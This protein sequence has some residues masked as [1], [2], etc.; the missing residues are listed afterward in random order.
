MKV[1]VVGSGGREHAL[2]R[3]IKKS[4]NVSSVYSWPGNAGH[5][6]DAQRVPVAAGDYQKLIAWAKEAQVELVVIGPEAELVAGLADQLRAAN[7]PVFGPERSAAQLE[8][9]KVFA[10]KFMHEFDIP[11]AQAQVVATVQQCLQAAEKFTAPYVL[12]ADGLAAG[13]GVFICQTLAELQSAA[14]DLFVNKKLGEAGAQALLEEFLPGQELSVLVLTNGKDYEVLPFTRDHKRLADGDRGPNTGGMGVIGPVEISSELREKIL[15]QVVTPSV[16]GLASRGYLY[17]GVL[18]IGVMI[19]SRGPI[20]LEYNVRFGDPETQVVLPLLAGDWGAVLKAV[21][22]GE[23]PKLQWQQNL[24][25]ACVVMAAEGYPDKP[26]KGVLITGDVTS[27]HSDS[28][29]LHAGTAKSTEQNQEPKNLPIGE[30]VTNGGRVLNVIGVGDDIPQ[31]L[32]NAYARVG[33]IT[34]PGCQFRKDIGCQ[35]PFS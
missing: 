9:S 6:I 26:V 15:M 3:A 8:G 10:K 2:I 31:A 29:V 11:T 28:Y 19:T 30:F 5:F 34:W 4:A 35:A 14:E 27:E 16:H 24:A 1:L 21:A 20:V 32:R 33:K 22:A 25:A 18:F 12:K 7:L 13:K 17:R 23:M